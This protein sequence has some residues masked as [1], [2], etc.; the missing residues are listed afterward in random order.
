MADR[1][2]DVLEALE[3]DLDVVVDLEGREVRLEG[4]DREVRAT[5]TE[6]GVEQVLTVTG[7]LHDGVARKRDEHAGCSRGLDVQHHHHVGALTLDA[8]VR[9][10]RIADLTRVGTDQQV[11]GRLPGID[12][13]QVG[14]VDRR[15]LV[16]LLLRD[17]VADRDDDAHD[18]GDDEA[19]NRQPAREHKEACRRRSSHARRRGYR[20]KPGNYRSGECAE[21]RR[22]L[23]RARERRRGSCG[24]SPSRTPRSSA[25]TRPARDRDARAPAPRPPG[26]G[27]RTSRSGARR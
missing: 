22:R 10:F 12:L 7:D 14:D 3:V 17:R 9:E 27:P 2:D 8:A 16:E 18:D 11:V 19:R 13:D 20:D 21:E 5:V 26:R 23:R 15:R 25:S 1:V 4:F 6:R 24:S